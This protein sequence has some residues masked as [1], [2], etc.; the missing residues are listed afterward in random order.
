MSVLSMKIPCRF[1]VSCSLSR[2]VLTVASR[3]YSPWKSRD[4]ALLM[5]LA[6]HLHIKRPWQTTLPVFSI[7]AQHKSLYFLSLFCRMKAPAASSQPAMWPLL[8]TTKANRQRHQHQKMI[9]RFAFFQTRYKCKT[10]SRTW[11][12][13]TTCPQVL[14]EARIPIAVGFFLQF[15]W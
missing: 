1:A 5:K 12:F 4:V 3:H 6:S 10:S 13:I 11:W 9:S 2:A 15:E 14:L 7:K 8:Q